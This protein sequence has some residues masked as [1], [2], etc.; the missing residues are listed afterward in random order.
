MIIKKRIQGILCLLPF[1]VTTNSF[2]AAAATADPA[3]I[4]PYSAFIQDLRES[5]GYAPSENRSMHAGS[6][7][8]V[9]WNPADSSD[10]SIAGMKVH[11]SSLAGGTKGKD[12]AHAVTWLTKVLP[13]L[14]SLNVVHKVKGCWEDYC[15]WLADNKKLV[16]IYPRDNEHLKVVL[17]EV[18]KLRAQLIHTKKILLEADPIKEREFFP[19]VFVRWGRIAEIEVLKALPE[20]M[21]C[22]SGRSLL[23]RQGLCG[24]LLSQTRDSVSWELVDSWEHGIMNDLIFKTHGEELHVEQFTKYRLDISI[25]IEVLIRI[26]YP[27]WYVNG[28]SS[29]GQS[30]TLRT[31]LRAAWT[32]HLSK[33][34]LQG[35][36]SS[37]I[38]QTLKVQEDYRN[39]FRRRAQGL[40]L[41]SKDDAL[42]EIFWD[43]SKEIAVPLYNFMI[44]NNLY[45]IDTGEGFLPAD[46]EHLEVPLNGLLEEIK[47]EIIAQSPSYVATFFK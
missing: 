47:A 10:F 39:V 35:D 17:T 29:Y 18:C 41:T 1:F 3:D 13:L 27:T 21:S 24:K 2:G 31:Q 40:K 8:W 45:V 38:E 43:C 19:G 14:Q 12:S 33:V 25:A 37:L 16:V 22:L 23:F 11:L 34:A 42:L 20:Q 46:M 6:P 15:S 4:P 28:D 5:H 26:K 9:Q 44:E 7:A 36:D 30:E 32:R